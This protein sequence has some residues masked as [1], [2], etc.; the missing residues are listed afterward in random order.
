MSPRAIKIVAVATLAHL[1]ALFFGIIG[2]L[3][4]IPN[5]DQ[6]A[7]NARAMEVYNWSIENAG[8]T[9]IIF[10]A[11]AMFLFGMFSIGFAKTAIFFVASFVISLTSELLGT[12]TGWPFG[13]YAYTDYLGYK[14][15]DHV[16]FSIP[17]SWFYIGFACYL[18]ACVIVEWLELKHQGFWRVALGVWFLTVWDLVLDPAMAHADVVPQFWTWSETGPYFGMP[19][20]NFIGWSVTGLVYMAVSR[21]LWRE[22]LK[23]ST[24]PPLFPMI[25][26]VANMAFAMAISLGVG[27]WI[28]VVLALILGVLPAGYAFQAKKDHDLVLAREASRAAAFGD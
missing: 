20:K 4:V 9:H 18:L 22:E 21:I 26:F 1:S 12:S 25:I 16:P 8:A 27:L 10:G 24:I 6:F 28:P 5:L 23:A 14:V 7:G 2:I 19:I 3:Y 15:L 11:I 17:L 13:N